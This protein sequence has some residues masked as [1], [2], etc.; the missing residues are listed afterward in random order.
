MKRVIAILVVFALVAGAA[1]AEINFGGSFGYKAEIIKGQ[2]TDADMGGTSEK[3]STEI[4]S[5]AGV[6][7]AQLDLNF[8]DDEGKYG[9]R[10]R[11]YANPTGPWWNGQQDYVPFAFAWWKP[12]EQFKVW[13]GYNPEGELG[14]AQITGWGFHTEAEDYVAINSFRNTIGDFGGFY[15][16][17]KEFGAILSVYPIDMLA[18]NIV[19]P[20]SKKDKVDTD[21]DTTPDKDRYVARATYDVFRQMH[22]NAVLKIENIG[23][24]TLSWKGTSTGPAGNTSSAGNIYVS[25]NLTA[26]E[27]LN[28]D[29]GVGL[30]LPWKDASDV[31][32]N[33]PFGLGLGVTYGAGDFGIKFGFGAKFVKDGATD[34]SVILL[35]YY[36]FGA[37][38]GY[39]NLGLLLNIPDGG[40]DGPLSWCVNPYVK[41]PAGGPTFYAGLK[42][43]GARTY[44]GTA[45]TDTVEW[46]VP[47]GIQIYF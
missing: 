1:F 8:S 18:V 7:S 46:S 32:H 9:G 2:G 5:S 19:L 22:V 37:F 6:V 14:T 38:T 13:L 17:F 44:A 10:V 35:P 3:T 45:T 16:G 28:V 30:G 43:Q 25:F 4:S 33:E 41:V 11:L 15:G 34:M 23:N 36:N 27:N 12:F 47:V 42:L 29:L 31:E 39:L 40:G 21:Y 26:V 24:A 20:F